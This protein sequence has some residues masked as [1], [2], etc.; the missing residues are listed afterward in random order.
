MRYQAR[1]IARMLM[2]FHVPAFLTGTASKSAVYAMVI[3]LLVGYVVKISH[4][5]TGGYEIATLEKK[6]SALTDE[7]SKL[8]AEVAS[9]QSIAS[10]QKRLQGVAMVPAENITYIKV[11]S[12]TMADR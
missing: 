6:V 8:N 2:S 10:I 12:L 4:L 5:T 1:S 9:Y 11:N 3:L 7:S